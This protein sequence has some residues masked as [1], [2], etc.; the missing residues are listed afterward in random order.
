MFSKFQE[1]NLFKG[2]DG[3]E[4]RGNED[5]L[6]VEDPLANPYPYFDAVGRN[7]QQFDKL[8]RILKVHYVSGFWIIS[9]FSC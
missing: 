5:N 9:M 6:D 2:T 4:I 7:C 3:N 8:F 1:V